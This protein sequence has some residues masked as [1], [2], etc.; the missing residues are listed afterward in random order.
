M[1]K[2]L[3]IEGDTNIYNNNY[4]KCFQAK[5][6]EEE[7]KMFNLKVKHQNFVQEHL[8]EEFVKAYTHPNR[9]NKLINTGYSIEELDYI[10]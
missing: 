3:L 8:W 4:K 6:G 9:I 10:L 2:G 7:R 1:K 5:M